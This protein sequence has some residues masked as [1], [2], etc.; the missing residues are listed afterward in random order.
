MLV[1]SKM[2]LSSINH[3]TGM[4]TFQLKWKASLVIYSHF[5]SQSYP[6]LF[7]CQLLSVSQP[8]PAFREWTTLQYAVA[9]LSSILPGVQVER[10]VSSLDVQEVALTLGYPVIKPAEGMN[11][12]CIVMYI[13][14]S[15]L[16]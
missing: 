4:H 14:L 7:V 15:C 8:Y 5:I 1:K 9:G 13:L 6:S 2:Q 10:V 16:N 12:I 11:T 3:I